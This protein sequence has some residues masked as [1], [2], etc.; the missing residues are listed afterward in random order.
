MIEDALKITET[1]LNSLR[2]AI[3]EIKDLWDL[4]GIGLEDFYVIKT[5]DTLVF[6]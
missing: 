1:H 3:E 4:E 5:I 2:R 6:S